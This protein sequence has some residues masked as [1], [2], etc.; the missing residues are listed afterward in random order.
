MDD[1]LA[2]RIVSVLQNTRP[3]QSMSVTSRPLNDLWN[4]LNS[5]LLEL[6][7]SIYHIR[8]GKK[9]PK[10][11]ARQ[12][13]IQKCLALLSAFATVFGT[14]QA[15]VSCERGLPRS[16]SFQPQP[17]GLNWTAQHALSCKHDIP[18]PIGL[19]E[20]HDFMFLAVKTVCAIAHYQMGHMRDGTATFQFSLPGKTMCAVVIRETQTHKSFDAYLE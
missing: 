17:E 12:A 9:A 6:R 11:A 20:T 8:L 5:T 14:R 3:F 16:I 15:I 2:D 7:G 1:T 18:Q 13:T 10:L 19:V 4:A